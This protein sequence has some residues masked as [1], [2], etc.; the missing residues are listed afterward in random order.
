MILSLGYFA[1][2]KSFDYRNEL[3]TK[4]ALQLINEGNKSILIVYGEAHVDPGNSKFWLL[5]LVNKALK[6]KTIKVMLEQAGVE[7]NVI[8][9]E[10]T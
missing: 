5:R 3:V 6:F 7:T 9:V 10:F 2:I 1:I 4:G 8:K